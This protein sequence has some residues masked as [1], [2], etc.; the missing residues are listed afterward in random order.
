M[1]R[2]LSLVVAAGVAQ[3]LMGYNALKVTLNDGTTEYVGIMAGSELKFEGQRMDI[4]GQG[5]TVSYEMPNV[6]H[7][8]FADHEQLGSISASIDKDDTSVVFDGS[9]LKVVNPKAT[10]I[11]IFN[12]AGQKM[13]QQQAEASTEA[14]I[15]ISGLAEGSYIL[16]CGKS[17]IKFIKKF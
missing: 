1:K 8:T 4:V 5:V 7:Y 10:L 15:D 16:A 14:S 12:V 9:A 13:M 6:K 17:R 3:C 11:E 2:I